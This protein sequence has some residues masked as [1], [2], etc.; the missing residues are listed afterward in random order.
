M[1][2]ASREVHQ[3]CALEMRLKCGGKS[4]AAAD[5]CLIYHRLNFSPSCRQAITGFERVMAPLGPGESLAH[6]RPYSR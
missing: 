2:T 1:G 3:A 5:R 6:F 4:G